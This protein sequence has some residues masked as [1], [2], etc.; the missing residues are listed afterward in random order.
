MAKTMRVIQYGLGPIGSATARYVNR[1]DNMELVA[2]VDVDR[3][4]IGKDVGEVAG[5]GLPLGFPVVGALSELHDRVGADVAIHTTSSYFDLFKSQILELGEAGLNVVSTA[6]ELSFP[7]LANPEH[8][9]EIDSQARAH[10]VTV[11][12]TG[13]N[14]GFIMDLLPL[15]L[16]AICQQVDH[17]D[18]RR[19]INASNRRASFQRKIGS[20]MTVEEFR[21]KM[22]EGKM[23]HVGL[24]ESVG[25]IFQASGK[26]LSHYEIN[27]EPVVAT[28]FVETEHFKIEEGRVRGLRQ[29]ARGYSRQGEF[30]SLTFVAAL[31]EEGEGD[32]IKIT[33]TPTI[34]AKLEGTNGDLATAA[35][36]VNAIGRVVESPPGL[37]TMYDLPVV[38]AGSAMIES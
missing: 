11:L 37:V 28:S 20:A 8:A 10:G 27:V 6:E 15:G 18:I 30:V 36:A 24:P 19:I 23:G 12:G 5:L 34:T 38:T 14:P 16:T 3:D 29:V 1:R 22:S 26:E 33:G 2:G 7:W 4:K 32:T 21:S 13:V 17:I 31:E 9:R 35:I 25:M